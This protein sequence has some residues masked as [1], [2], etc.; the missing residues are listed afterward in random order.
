MPEGTKA[1]SKLTEER[2]NQLILYHIAE[3][4][5]LEEERDAIF[6]KDLQK[7]LTRAVSKSTNVTRE[8]F[9]ELLAPL[10]HVLGVC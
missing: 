3:Q 7:F 1:V 10:Y 4:Q 2:V 9:L 8:E 6:R 5:R